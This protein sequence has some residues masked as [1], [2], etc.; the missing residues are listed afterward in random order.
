[1]GLTSSKQK[2]EG[3]A[4]GAWSKEDKDAFV[5]LIGTNQD[6]VK[7]VQDRLKTDTGFRSTFTE[8]LTQDIDFRQKVVEATMVNQDFKISIANAIKSDSSFVTALKPQLQGSIGPK[9]DRGEKGDPGPAGGPA[10]PQGPQGVAGPAG[11]PGPQ[12]ET[13]PKGET[14]PAAS[15]CTG[16]GELC[17]FLP[18]GKKGFEWGYGGSKI[19]DDANLKVESDDNV[20][21][22]T[23]GK[24]S[25]IISKNGATSGAPSDNEWSSLA[26]NGNEAGTAPVASI[27][28]NGPARTIDGGP[29]TMTMRNDK[30]NLRLMTTGESRIHTDSSSF[31]IGG[32]LPGR[33]D[34]PGVNIWNKERKD[35]SHFGGN[36]STTGYTNFI[37][38]ATEVAGDVS[39]NN[40]ALV[41][42]SKN[43]HKW[44]IAVLDN[45]DLNFNKAGRGSIVL[46]QTDAPKIFT[47]R[48]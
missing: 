30:G 10:G 47:W 41:L 33:N 3:K 29:D 2:V 24:N 38:G 40:G 36:A 4:W 19:Y 21:I 44:A 27:F 31:D 1:M 13:G 28:K 26:L 9:G 20:I 17:T 23:H 7:I 8:A 5:S 15:W 42:Q 43:G 6:F 39:V 16:G 48:D 46:H 25:L 37:R 32:I 22:K 12:G 35:W 14:G 34:F 45:G 11:G 18:T